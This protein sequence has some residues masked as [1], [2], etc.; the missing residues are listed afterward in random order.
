MLQTKHR[1]DAEGSLIA[2]EAVQTAS[3]VVV[4]DGVEYMQCISNI[5]STA[6]MFHLVSNRYKS[7]YSSGC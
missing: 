7:L 4:H 3:I 6:N 1:I 2:V 5:D